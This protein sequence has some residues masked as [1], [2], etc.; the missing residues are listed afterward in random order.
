MKSLI[1]GRV[2]DIVDDSSP[3]T[4]K[5]VRIHC[6]IALSV[7]VPPKKYICGH[8]IVRFVSG[9]ILLVLFLSLSQFLVC[10]LLP[11]LPFLQY[12]A[13]CLPF[14]DSQPC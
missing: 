13:G 3:A 5:T 4:K 11:L 7:G 2:P 10:F 8:I 9:F 1:V 12:F 14:K 6:I